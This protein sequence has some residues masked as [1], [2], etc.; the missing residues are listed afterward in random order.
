MSKRVYVGIASCLLGLGLFIHG[1]NKIGNYSEYLSEKFTKHINSAY[2]MQSTK[3]DE[4]RIKEF[5]N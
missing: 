5:N 4:E 1:G 2:S 3:S